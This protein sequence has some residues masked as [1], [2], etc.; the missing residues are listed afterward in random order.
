MR[1]QQLL[2]EALREELD[3]IQKRNPSFS[4][5]SFSKKLELS[6]A[7]LSRVLSGKRSVSLPLARKISEKLGLSDEQ[8]AQVLAPI[9]LRESKLRSRTFADRQLN[10]DTFQAVAD[11][12]HF[13]ILSLL[14]TDGATSDVSWISKRLAIPERTASAALARL[15]RL[16]LLAKDENGAWKG[17]GNSH[18]SPDGIPSPAV[19]KAHRQALSLGRQAL[20][21]IPVERRDFTTL[22]MAIDPEKLPEAVKILRE[23][24]TRVNNLLEGGKRKQVYMLAIQLFPID[25][26]EELSQQ[27]QT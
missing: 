27:V 9:E 12:H 7:T 15:G 26:I 5:R 11:W 20:D 16:G 22:M 6:P 19:R 4:L 13:A 23:A 21:R 2:R 18:H 3:R 25:Q 1:E 24:R 10:A 17:T 8:K 14:E